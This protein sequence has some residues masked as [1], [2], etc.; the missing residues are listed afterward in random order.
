[1]VTFELGKVGQNAYYVNKWVAGITHCLESFMEDNLRESEFY[2][3]LIDG[4]HLGCC[5]IYEDLF[6]VTGMRS[7]T[8]FMLDDAALGQAEKVFEALLAELKPVNALCYSEDALFF[9][10][11][12]D[13]HLSVNLQAFICRKGNRQVKDPAFPFEAMP[14]IGETEFEAVRTLSKGWCDFLAVPEKQGHFKLYMLEEA[15]EILGLGL[16]EDS[17]LVPGRKSLGIY[18]MEGHRQRGVARSVMLHLARIC[19]QAGYT[20]VTGCYY[21]NHNSH[22]TLVSAGFDPVYRIYRVAFTKEPRFLT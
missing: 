12:M 20:P 1:M 15:G 22:R 2:S 16:L 13:H 11:A 6:D 9:N 19:Q 17:D 4:V 21:Y 14:P 3:I 5:A 7:L 10:L 8:L 18:T